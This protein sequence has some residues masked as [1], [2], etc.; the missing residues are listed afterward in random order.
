[1]EERE[2]RFSRQAPLLGEEGMKSM[3]LSTVLIH[4]LNGVG[5]EIAKNI[6]LTGVGTVLLHDGSDLQVTDLSSQFFATFEEVGKNKVDVCLDKLQQLNELTRVEKYSGNLG[7]D[8]WQIPTP[9]SVV[10][11][12]NHTLNAQLCKF[13]EMCRTHNT[14]LVVV[15]VWGL[16]G[17]IISDFGSSFKYLDA[18]GKEYLDV[19]LAKT[20][21]DSQNKDWMLVTANENLDAGIDGIVPDY[22]V[23]FSCEDNQELNGKIA[24]ITEVVQEPINGANRKRQFK[25]NLGNVSNKISHNGR[26]SRVFISGEDSHETIQSFVSSAHSFPRDPSKTHAILGIKTLAKFVEREGRIPTRNAHDSNLFLEISEEIVAQHKM[27]DTPIRFDAQ[28]LLK[29]AN[30]I[31]GNLSPL[32]AIF[33]GLGAQEALKACARC[34][35]PIP[36]FYS[37]NLLDWLHVPIHSEIKAG[38]RYDGQIALFGE[39]V[40]K[41]LENLRLFVV[42]AG[43]VGCE[44]LKNMACMGIACG[45]EGTIHLTDVDDIALSNLHRQF[46]YRKEHISQQ[47]SIVAASAIKNLNPQIQIIPHTALFSESSFAQFGGDNFMENLD[48]L[49]PAVDNVEARVFIDS[50]ALFYAKPMFDSGTEGLSGTTQVILPTGTARYMGSSSNPIQNA[51]GCYEK[52]FPYLSEHTI[53]I[54]LGKFKE[55]FE[56]IPKNIIYNIHPNTEQSSEDAPQQKWTSA[57]FYKLKEFFDEKALLPRK[58]DEWLEGIFTQYFI[59]HVKFIREKYPENHVRILNDREEPF[60]NS[61]VHR[62]HPLKFDPS[63]DACKTFCSAGAS[64]LKDLFSGG[65]INPLEFEKDELAHVDFVYAVSCL[66]CDCYS[67]PRPQKYKIRYVAGKMSIAIINSTAIV[68]GMTCL[69]LLRWALDSIPP[70]SSSPSSSAPSSSSS[71]LAPSPS[72]APSSSSTSLSPSP[73]H[74]M[75]RNISFNMAWNEVFVTTPLSSPPLPPPSA[76]SP[77]SP[78]AQ[79][80]AHLAQPVR[81][82]VTALAPLSP[83]VIYYPKPSESRQKDNLQTVELWRHPENGGNCNGAP[84]DVMDLRGAL[85]YLHK[86]WRYP[87]NFQPGKYLRLICEKEDCDNV[88]VKV[89]LQH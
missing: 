19:P 89:V 86:K 71:L 38:S 78:L 60:W 54:A 11:V 18:S 61:K 21:P 24:Q 44:L 88:I 39:D 63:D 81:E 74:K 87:E 53:L 29:V 57:Q 6:I 13:D 79:I 56:D 46:L 20:E 67:I 65:S 8:L 58:V 40:Q 42:G 66:L 59:S 23:K 17:L 82:L 30:T 33:G 25:V 47:K 70:S 85:E 9:P 31:Q 14:K 27:S 80:H 50:L 55:L 34:Y 69:N 36:T 75:Y 28:I 72:P 45:R 64:L 35:S 51:I 16:C 52:S 4:G 26:A 15:E 73:P 83:Y 1:M 22:W 62:P 2:T 48:A 5:V 84:D 10:V 7:E 68:A 43:A 32:A 49:V 12:I 76:L 3:S 77:L 41:A 37:L